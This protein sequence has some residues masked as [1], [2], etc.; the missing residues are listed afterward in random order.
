MAP[1]TPSADELALALLEC[2][3][4]SLEAPGAMAVAC[5]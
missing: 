1:E 5:G 2:Q 3:L 4:M